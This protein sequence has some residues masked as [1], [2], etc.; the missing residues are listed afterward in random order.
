M[1]ATLTSMIVLFGSLVGPPLAGQDHPFLL[2]SL[3]VTASPTPRPAGA[4]GRSVTVLEGAD[5]RARGLTRVAEALRGVP[6]VTVTQGG[7]FGATTSVFLR[8]GE[9]DHVQVLVDGV[10][11]NQPGGAFDFASLTLVNVERIEIVRGPASSLFGSDAVAGVIHVISRAGWVG[12]RATIAARGGSHG[13]LD[14]S[15]DVSGGGAGAGWAVAVQHLRTD[16]ILPVNNAHRSSTLSGNVRLAPDE[17]TRVQVSVRWTNRSYHFPTDGAGNVADENSFTFGD[18]ATLGLSLSRWLTGGL[19]V[20]GEVG[21]HQSDLGTD[22]QPDGPADTLGYVGFSNLDHVR[23]A[24]VDGQLNLHLSGSVVTAGIEVEEQAVR[25]HSESR[26]QWGAAHGK[27]DNQRWN[28]AVFLHWTGGR[29]PVSYGVGGRMEDNQRFGGSES[30]N[31]EMTW[32][33][34][35]STRVRAS[36]GR[37]VKEPTF[38]ENFAQGYATGNPDLAPEVG[39]SWDVGLERSLAGER[40]DVH[41][42]YFSQRFRDLIQYSS[43]TPA[44]GGPNYFN[45]ARANARGVEAG[46]GLRLGAI[47]AGVDWTWLHTMVRDAG[48]EGAAEGDFVQGERLLRRPD[49]EM[50]GHLGAEL[51]WGYLRIEAKTTGSRDDRDFST[52]PARRVTLPR[53]TTV[54]VGGEVPLWT[55]MPHGGELA[56]TFRIDNLT[57]VSYEDI[58]GFPAPGRVIYL[59]GRTS[60]GGD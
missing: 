43:T 60:F 3:V 33:V 4:V 29:G 48:P 37:S 21:V 17:R 39:L 30:W 34:V 42:A 16:G 23:R 36:A 19:E 25:S 56:V 15:A 9:S 8:G 50:S 2:D 27:S 45:V 6:G 14:F 18:E 1:T 26:S 51:G 54:A 52:F 41:V 46:I 5:L 32:R 10:Q 24:T 57:D 31:S 7:S 35:P 58:R 44:L 11:V 12:P 13:W 20:R 53:H 59:G 49:H 47:R 40:V 22:D 28:R 55:E 38:Y